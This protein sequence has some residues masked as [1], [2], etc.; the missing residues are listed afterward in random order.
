MTKTTDWRLV[1]FLLVDVPLG[2]NQD[3]L[4]VAVVKFP[5]VPTKDDQEE[6]DEVEARVRFGTPESR[7]MSRSNSLSL[8]NW[9]NEIAHADSLSSGNIRFSLARAMRRRFVFCTN[10]KQ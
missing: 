7:G 6:A 1:G 10:S 5:G 8:P 4:K 9:A 2:N 3:A